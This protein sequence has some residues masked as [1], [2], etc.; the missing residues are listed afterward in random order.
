MGLT[1]SSVVVVDALAPDLPIVYVN[2]AFSEVTGYPAA[3]AV[4]RNCR[5]LQGPDTD[6][7]A[8]AELA[9]ALRRGQ[10]HQST[11]LN[12]RR[13]GSTWWNEVHVSPLHDAAG[14]VTHFVG[15]QHDVS[16]RVAAEAAL[17][18]RA[19]TDPLTG[20]LNRTALL[21]ELD[22]QVRSAGP[23]PV[24]LFVDL[25]GFKRVNDRF[26]HTVGDL[27]LGTVADRLRSVV[28]TGDLLAR[29]GGD[30]F[31]LVLAQVDVVADEAGPA[32]VLAGALAAAHRV[33]ADI[34]R[35]LAVPVELPGGPMSIGASIGVAVHP[36]DGET[37]AELL[38]TADLQMY[39]SK[40]RRARARATT[41]RPA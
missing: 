14:Q 24:V 1:G 31:V 13:D 8:L 21:S 33:A 11:L 36:A 26:G 25:D 16:D 27:A 28:R 22:R 20:T 9:E 37:P 39:R 5:F 6:R 18:E 3:E 19:G 7:A 40:A 4:G 23:G 38:R 32:S 41:G 15:L 29:L 12:V 34:E 17:R 10:P 35:V 30:E 2:E